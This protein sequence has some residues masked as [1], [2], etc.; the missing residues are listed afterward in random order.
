MQKL[1][2]DTVLIANRGEIAVR[3]IKT[4]RKLGLRSAIVYHDVDAAT[5]AV[6]MADTAIALE[7][8]SPVAA[9]LDAEQIIASARRA[10]VDA[11]HPGYGFLSESAA[12]ARAVAGAGI[13]FVGP[14][15]ESIELMGDKIRARKFAQKIGFP[16]ALSAIEEDEPATFAS[17]ARALGL[18]LLVKP[19]AGGGGKG[20]RI[21]RDLDT[22]D[23]AIAQARREG[24]RHF[25][26]GRL[27]VERYVDKPRHIEVQVLGDLF[28]NVV[29]FFERECSVQ[30]RFQKIIEETPSPVLSAELRERICEMAVGIARSANYRNAGTVEFIFDGHEFYFLEMNTRLQVEH[31]V[32]EMVTG[33]DLVA[34]QLH[35]AAGHELTF[36]QADIVSKGH[37]IEA[38]LYAEAPEREYAPTSGKILMLE[39]PEC[40]GVRIDSGIVQGQQITAAFDPMLAKVV[41]HSATRR[42]AA[43]K[44]AHVMRQLVLLGCET[45]ADFLARLLMDDTFLSGHIHTGYLDEHPHLA[46]GPRGSDLSAIL[47][48]GALLTRSVRDS[49]DAVPRLHAELG[50][51][52]N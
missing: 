37:A 21:A 49:A 23:D 18:P 36:S 20:M 46:I 24:L 22:L 8:C 40:D 9:Y 4:L 28:G 14:S 43:L 30:R 29:H 7:G 33:V 47:A 26:D 41:V 34:E 16:V 39:Y 51:W 5:P 13:A 45:N 52:R 50:N 19:S 38:R 17:R 12:F 48:A 3:I 31:P 2:F 35:V 42:E 1:P 15:P 10:N 44:A 27:Y 32:T 11:L 6:S 25:G